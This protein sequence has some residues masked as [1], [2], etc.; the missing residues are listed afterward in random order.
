VFFFCF[1]KEAKILVQL[2]KKCKTRDSLFPFLK[3]EKKNTQ[4]LHCQT[5]VSSQKPFYKQRKK[6]FL[7]SKPNTALTTL[8]ITHK[9]KTGQLIAT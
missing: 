5:L 6:F 8:K 3:K 9:V 7:L 1:S 2:M 4:L